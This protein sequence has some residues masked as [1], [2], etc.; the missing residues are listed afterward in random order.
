MALA[1]RRSVPGLGERV[2]RSSLE[3]Y[4]L[5]GEHEILA[6]R[7]HWAVVAEPVA[8]A[9]AGLLLVGA[10]ALVMPASLN[11]LTNILVWAWFALVIRALWRWLLWRR[12]WLVATD[13]RL[14]LT[15]GL[16]TEKVAMM[17]LA[18]V[19]DMSYNRSPMGR[20]LGYGTF[21]MESAGQDQALRRVAWV[22][23]PD[24]TYRAICAEIFEVEY[25]DRGQDDEHEHQFEDG[26][27]PHTPGLYAGYVPPEERTGAADSPIA[28]DH[29][30]ES[31]IAIRY[32]GSRQV[33][34]DPW[35]QS[36]DLRESVIRDAD[37]GPIPYGRPTADVDDEWRP[38]RGWK[39]DR[40]RKKDRG[41]Q[42]DRDQV[43][44]GRD[45]DPDRDSS[46]GQGPGSGS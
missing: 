23:H 41:Q 15:Y 27:P 26:P 29:E 8:S 31:G 34:Q 32:A 1:R 16:I 20:L 40:G 4:V 35:R 45:Q 17:P 18:K 38:A 5:E 6:Q 22:K 42:Q 24:H 39:K 21:V 44:P 28:S 14:L 13:K 36:A 30:D 37:T 10:I 2:R 7:R 43:E 25:H 33:D 12:D 46:H 19:T 3:R 11:I 9:I